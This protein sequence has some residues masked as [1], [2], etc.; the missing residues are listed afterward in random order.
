M[1][2]EGGLRLTFIIYYYWVKLERH[3]LYHMPK[4]T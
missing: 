1:Y 4:R 3:L 2:F